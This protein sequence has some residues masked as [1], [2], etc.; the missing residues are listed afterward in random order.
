MHYKIYYFDST[1]MKKRKPLTKEDLHFN[2][3]RYAD[4]YSDQ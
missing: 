1:L 3:L 2:N 4:I